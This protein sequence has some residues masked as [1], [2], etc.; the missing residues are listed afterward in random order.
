MSGELVRQQMLRL[1]YTL[2]AGDSATATINPPSSPRRPPSMQPAISAR[3]SWPPPGPEK[4]LSSS[5]AAQDALAAASDRDVYIAAPRRDLVTQLS[6]TLSRYG[7]R[8]G[9]I[10]T[11]HDYDPA[12]EAVRM[13]H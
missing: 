13:R 10:A 8:H 9:Y 4:A 3:S 6:S 12:R 1:R 2:N 5:A 7:L 11:R